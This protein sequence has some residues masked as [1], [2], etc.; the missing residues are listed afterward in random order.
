MSRFVRILALMLTIAISVV[1]AFA[2]PFVLFPQAGQLVSPDRRFVL[3]SVEN[4]SSSTEFVGTFRALWVTELATGRSRKLCDYMGV[5]AAAWAGDNYL[6]VTQ[7]LAK[8]TSR[9]LLF[10]MS[11]TQADAML[12]APT[13]TRLVPPEM[14]EPLR[15]ND[16]VFVEASRLEGEILHVHV[17]GYGRHDPSGFRWNCQYGLRDGRAT[18][19]GEKPSP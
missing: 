12:D 14:R 10:A 5:A 11:D 7:Y 3:R 17:W 1:P 8:K 4:E 6:L 15:E 18:C 2:A 9:A 16:H 19:A 13:L